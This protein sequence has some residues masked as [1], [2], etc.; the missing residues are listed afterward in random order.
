MQL[1]ADIEDGAAF[2]G[3]AAQHHKQH[4]HGLGRE[5]RGGLVQNQ[6]AGIGQQGAD[7]F[8][9]LH[10]ADGKRVHGAMR[11]HLQPVIA[12]RGLNVLDH[13]GQC[14]ALVQAQPDVLGH[15]QRVEQA[16]MLEHH[17]NA[18]CPG[19][20]RIADLHR[21]AV[22]QDGSLIRLDRTVDDL[23]QRGLASAVFAQDGV[24]LAGLNFQRYL[25]VCNHS[26]VPLGNTLQLQTR[27]RTRRGGMCRGGIHR[28]IVSQFK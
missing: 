7:D 12:G 23:H 6:H 2:R 9:A 25:A 22:D 4:L 27:R 15:G 10:F 24:D 18:Q 20:L 8:H 21:L 11:V 1:V 5:H 28:W 19:F 13:L 3:Q 17:G 26:R 14:N 16:E